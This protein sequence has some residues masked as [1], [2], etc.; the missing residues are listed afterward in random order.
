MKLQKAIECAYGNKLG[1]IAPDAVFRKFRID[2][3]RLGFV[4]NMG[5]C[6]IFGCRA[7]GIAFTW[8]KD[9]IVK[10]NLP[11]HDSERIKFERFVI[12]C[13]RGLIK[14]GEILT[15]EDEE[16]LNLAVERLGDWC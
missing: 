6:A 13:A 10:L 2:P 7:D 11:T 16:R 14:R 4:V 1:Y 3:Y 9:E 8:N 5:E 12:E 15:P